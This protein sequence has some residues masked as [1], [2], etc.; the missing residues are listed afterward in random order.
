MGALKHQQTKAGTKTQMHKKQQKGEE[1]TNGGLD[2]FIGVSGGADRDG[3]S[4]SRR[5]SSARGE[6]L[7]ADPL[8]RQ[9][10]ELGEACTGHAFYSLRRKTEKTRKRVVWVC[11]DFSC[12]CVFDQQAALKWERRRKEAEFLEESAVVFWSLNKTMNYQSVIPNS[13]LFTV[14]HLPKG[15]NTRTLILISSNYT[16]YF[17]F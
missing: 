2:E 10:V 17:I 3:D 16:Y 15:N 6:W 9:R 1:G 4:A 7:L 8:G 14:L 13:P 5:R 11:D 12:V